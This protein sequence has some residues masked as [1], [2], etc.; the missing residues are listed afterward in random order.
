[1]MSVMQAFRAGAAT[2]PNMGAIIATQLI[3][4]RGVE[5]LFS[6]QEEGKASFSSMFLS[7]AIVGAIS[8]PPLAIFNGQTMG[9]SAWQSVQGLQL[10]QIGAIVLRETSFL[11]ALGIS[12]PICA[13]MQQAAG[14]KDRKWIELP[15]A[16]V[17]GVTSGVVSHPAD[18]ALTLWQRKMKIESAR[19]LMQGGFTR[20]IALG[21]FFVC[22]TGATRIIES[23]AQTKMK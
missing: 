20:A 7:A 6:K 1:M 8:A 11:F 12:S 9:R 10:R 15:V 23:I 13:W 5:K 14:D 16:F 2:A 18:T 3:A 19:Q 21:G 4:K 22:Y 17:T